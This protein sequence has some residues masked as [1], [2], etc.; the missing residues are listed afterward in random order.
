MKTN[1]GWAPCHS[2]DLE[3]T[4]MPAEGGGPADPRRTSKGD[5]EREGDVLKR[6]I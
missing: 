5:E 1:G 3:M 6:G 2:D 4:A